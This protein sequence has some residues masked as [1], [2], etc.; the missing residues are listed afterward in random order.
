MVSKVE[1][2][3]QQYEINKARADA[4]KAALAELR[5]IQNQ[6]AKKEARKKRNH[7]LFESAGLMIL[8]DLVVSESGLPAVDRGALLGGLMAVAKTLEHG[9]ESTRFQ[10]WKSAGDALLAEREAARQSPQAK[11]PATAPDQTPSESFIT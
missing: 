2:L 7:A 10:E 9:P 4:A 8:A 5:R 6:K 3:Q 1:R 11:N